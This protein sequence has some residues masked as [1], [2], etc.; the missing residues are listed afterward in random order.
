M[1]CGME[2]PDDLKKNEKL[3]ENIITPTT[4]SERHDELISA[5]E[6]IKSNLMTSEEWEVASRAALALFKCGQEMAR[7]S[8]LLL[9]DTK[10]EFG[11]DKEGE[12][13]LIDEVN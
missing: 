1:Y 9:V 11:R 2:F 6:I 13:Y 12:I 3:K 10:Y 8:G 5:K 7:E 4:K